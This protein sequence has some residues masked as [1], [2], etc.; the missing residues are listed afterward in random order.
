MADAPFVRVVTDVTRNAMK[1]RRGTSLT[2]A[3]PIFQEVVGA[4]R[5]LPEV[6]VVADTLSAPIVRI[7]AP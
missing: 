3:Y 2:I 6:F 5:T 4:T 1:V 7:L